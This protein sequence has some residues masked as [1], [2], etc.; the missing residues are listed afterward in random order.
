MRWSGSLVK[1]HPK[2]R[3]ASTA[4]FRCKGWRACS[5]KIP[6]AKRS[7]IACR[8][9]KTARKMGIKTVAVYSEA[10]QD[11]LHVEMAAESVFIGPPPTTHQS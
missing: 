8:M 3:G 1:R 4:I 11:A 5:R 7:E 9:I 6:I 10:D 2:I